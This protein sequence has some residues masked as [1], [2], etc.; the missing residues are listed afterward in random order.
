MTDVAQRIIEEPD[1]EA[2]R[3][4]VRT[5]LTDELQSLA[6]PLFGHAA[7]HSIEFRR[8]W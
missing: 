6:G 5:W 3:L 8:A 4:G 1:D 7:M 2:F